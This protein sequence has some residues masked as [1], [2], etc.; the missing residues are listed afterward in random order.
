MQ[1]SFII[2]LLFHGAVI[3]LAYFGIPL[4][5]DRELLVDA[6]IVVEI[7]NIDDESNV[8]AP[9]PKEKPEPKKPEPPKEKPKLPPPAPKPPA[10]AEP[11]PVAEPEPEAEAEP[12]VE[13]KLEKKPEPKP[14]PEVVKPKPRLARVTL[15]K[16]PKPPKKELDFT[17]LMKNLDLK[18]TP[19]VETKKEDIPDLD[20]FAKDIQAAIKK[21]S[22]INDASRPLSISEIDALRQHIAK[23][24]NPPIG[25]RD[26][27]NLK[28]EIEVT[29]NPDATVRA[30]SIGSSSNLSDPFYRAAAESALRAVNNRRCWPYPLSQET[31]SQWQNMTLVFDPRELLGL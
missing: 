24:W 20:D 3:S 29:M 11:E 9:K 31:Y 22:K 25:A 10:P 2:S 13:K 19:K 5:P 17:S 1:I 12:I 28:I 21:P 6:P 4:L 16:K 27:E 14:K 18:K 30:A 8:P 26:A 23:C 15:S 7:I